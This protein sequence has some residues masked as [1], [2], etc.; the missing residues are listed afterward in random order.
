MN[1]EKFPFWFKIEFSTLSIF[2]IILFIFG[3]FVAF[4]AGNFFMKYVLPVIFIL[5]FLGISLL[6]FDKKSWKIF[7][8]GEIILVIIGIILWIILKYNS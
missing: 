4:G 7:I 1:L 5:L 8:S 6:S 2:A 3:I